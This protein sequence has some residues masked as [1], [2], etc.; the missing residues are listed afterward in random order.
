MNKNGERW[1]AVLDS[2]TVLRN[3]LMTWELLL[4]QLVDGNYRSDKRLLTMLQAALDLLEED[5]NRHCALEET[6]LYLDTKER[7]PRLRSLVEELWREH[8]VLRVHVE[9]MQKDLRGA[10]ALP[11]PEVLS[12]A[13]M[14]VRA[15][16]VELAQV[17]REHMRREENEL[18]PALVGRRSIVHAQGYLAAD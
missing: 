5:L 15:A 16:G 2:N 6:G 1:S 10:V 18:I 12:T 13:G 8:K 7:F 14:I 17:F 4:Y 11:D 9:A 3:H